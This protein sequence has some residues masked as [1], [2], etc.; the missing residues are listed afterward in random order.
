MAEIEMCYRESSTKGYSK[1][2]AYRL[3]DTSATARKTKV[4]EHLNAAKSTKVVT[5]YFFCA[6][7]A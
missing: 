6:S 3:Q 5:V 1:Y 7:E 2:L 4:R